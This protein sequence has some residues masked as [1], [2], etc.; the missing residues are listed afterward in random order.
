MMTILKILGIWLLC[1]MVYWANP[2]NNPNNPESPRNYYHPVNIRTRQGMAKE[3][4]KDNSQLVLN[5]YD[6]LPYLSPAIMTLLCVVIDTVL[7][8]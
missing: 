7:T 2:L 4:E 1:V 8:A 5:G 6:L 3:I